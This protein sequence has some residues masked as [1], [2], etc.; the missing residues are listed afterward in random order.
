MKRNILFASSVVLLLASLFGCGGKQADDA[1]FN[2]NIPAYIKPFAE[3]EYNKA[4]QKG[5]AL[6]RALFYDKNLSAAG[7]VSCASCHIQQK[8][9]SDGL[10]QRQSEL[11][12]NKLMR[13]APALINLGWMEG[14]FWDGGA[15]NLEFLNTGPLTS[16]DEMG[17][18]LRQL[19]VLLQKDKQYQH[20]FME[21]FGKDSIEFSDVSNALS[22]FSRSLISF[23]SAYDQW[24]SGGKELSEEAMKGYTLYKEHCSTC[25]TEGLFTDNSYHNNGLDS[26]FAND[27]LFGIEK[28]RY[29]ITRRAEDMGKFKTPTLRNLSFTAPYMHD[30]RFA[31]LQEVLQHYSGDLHQSATLDAALKGEDGSLGIDLSEADKMALTAFLEALTDYDFV[32]NPAYSAPD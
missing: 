29:R 10:P 22:Q 4:T 18:D 7:T 12:G 32:E 31:N 19:V 16:H 2:Y 1:S 9:F 28:G 5:V 14:Y 20:M 8:S 15:P 23:G 6:G 27:T 21:A 30:G 13:N 26:A 11:S 25:H 17:Q 24:K 3:P